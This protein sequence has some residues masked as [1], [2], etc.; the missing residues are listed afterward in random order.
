MVSGKELSP[1]RWS[2]AS[3]TP[4][5]TGTTT[6]CRSAI[7]GRVGPNGPALEPGNLGSGWVGFDFAAAFEC[8]VR[9][10]N[11]A[12][13]QAL[14]SY[15]GGRMLFLG[16]GTGVGSVLVVDHTSVPLELGELAYK[17]GQT[18][19]GRWAGARSRRWA[20][21][22]GAS[23]CSRWC[24]RCSGLPRRLRGP[25]RR[26]RQADAQDAAAERAPRPQPDRVPRRLSPVGHRGHADPQR[27]RQ[28]AAGAAAVGGVAASP[29]RSRSYRENVRPYDF[30]SGR[31]EARWRPATQRG[32]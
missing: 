2:S 18:L 29:G 27:E 3:A 24:R 8:P 21:S 10:M 28:G 32:P 13:M 16:L 1:A 26:Q 20:R 22:A 23:A 19:S 7:P 15:D 17:R 25:R 9:I 5:R 31:W 12:A 6:R 14:G 30:S 11:D 4:P